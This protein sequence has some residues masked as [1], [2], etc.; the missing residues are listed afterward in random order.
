MDLGSVRSPCS[1]LTEMIGRTAYDQALRDWDSYW[2][3]EGRAISAA[4]DRAGTPWL[5]MFDVAG[6]R[7]DEILYQP[8]YW[9]L[10]KQGY[11]S[12]VIWRAFQ[13]NSLLPSFLLI[14]LTSFYDCGLTC[15]YTVSLSTAIP[16]SKYGDEALK[17]RFLD[18]LLRRD[19]SV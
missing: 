7:V 15:P 14:Y 1:F 11:K 3:K 17:Q 2:E 13:D 6:K 18:K 12:G 16:L 9:R 5:R 8:E 4:V 10:L 19:D